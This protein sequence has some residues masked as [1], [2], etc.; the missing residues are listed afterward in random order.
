M[1]N[2]FNGENIYISDSVDYNVELKNRIGGNFPQVFEDKIAEINN[3]IFYLTIEHPTYDEKMITIFIPNDYESRIDN[4]IYPNCSIKVYITGFSLESQITSYTSQD[5]KKLSLKSFTEI[6]EEN[7]NG[8]LIKLG[9][10]PILIQDESY[11]YNELIKDG[12]TFFMQIDE[13]YYP[14]DLVIDSYPFGLGSLY[15]YAKWEDNKMVD[16]IA[17]F[18]QYS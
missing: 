8:S 16:L 1:I 9:G 18:W 14:D 10:D 12:Y 5:I 13:N 15:L 17:G 11:Y 3:Y 4:N 6:E 7:Y 2:K